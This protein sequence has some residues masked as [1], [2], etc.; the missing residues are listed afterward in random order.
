MGVSSDVPLHFHFHCLFVCF[1]SLHFYCLAQS[2]A[3]SSNE[4]TKGSVWAACQ[5]LR[6]AIECNIDHDLAEESGRFGLLQ[7]VINIFFPNGHNFK[8]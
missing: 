6:V 1:W 8:S 2:Q 3:Y 4:Y 7:G 5:A